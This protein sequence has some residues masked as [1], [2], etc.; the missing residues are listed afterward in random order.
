MSRD[1]SSSSEAPS[2]APIVS[3]QDS[4]QTSDRKLPW[5]APS[6]ILVAIGSYF[7]SQILAV[8]T[9]S[10][11]VPGPT[12]EYLT[13]ETNSEIFSILALVAVYEF[14]LVYL[15]VLVRGGRFKDLKI[16]RPDYKN[17]LKVVPVYGV[18]FLALIV[19]AQIAQYFLSTEVINQEQDIG[20]GVS[21]SSFE[22]LLIFTALV[23]IAPVLEEIVFRGF[24]FQGLLARFGSVWA[25][26]ISSGLFALAH[27]QVNVGID[28]FLLGLAACWLLVNSKSIWP[29]IALHALKNAIAFV[30]LFVV[31]IP[32]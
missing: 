14:I 17:L 20:F 2:E 18:Y 3:R 30:L 5:G 25:A 27:M 15:F 9:F 6:A 22:M 31:E 11:L 4:E 10:L 29:S 12:F 23:I 26:V 1:S 16:V 13:L 7:L 21:S 24:M 28:T 32:M 8:A 19:V